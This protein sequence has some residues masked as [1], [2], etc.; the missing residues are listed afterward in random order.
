MVC[1]LNPVRFTTV[2]LA[3]FAPTYFFA[4]DDRWVV[5][6][7]TGWSLEIE[8]YHLTPGSLCS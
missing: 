1:P 8:L 3:Q 6:G 2:A 7:D 4:E 5:G